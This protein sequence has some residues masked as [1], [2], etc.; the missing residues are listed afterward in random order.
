MSILNRTA[1]VAMIVFFVS[2][3]AFAGQDVKSG[4][5]TAVSKSDEKK[6][7]EEEMI[8]RLSNPVEGESEMD[9]RVRERA[10]KILL[11][12]REKD[13]QKKR[14]KSLS[15]VERQAA[16]QVKGEIKREAK[17]DKKASQRRILLGLSCGKDEDAET[18]P[19]DSVWVS[20]DAVQDYHRDVHSRMVVAN[21]TPF[22][23]DEI[24]LVAGRG[25][26]VQV[27]NFCVGGVINLVQWIGWNMYT[28]VQYVATVRD[29]S[30]KVSLSYSPLIVMQA[31]QS[32][33]CQREFSGV[34]EIQ[35][36]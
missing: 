13:A 4:D 31:C 15:L 9:A 29:E 20:N 6:E 2:G 30:G 33:T 26:P 19:T 14:E 27:K 8:I 11:E 12:K 7:T 16:A 5:K 24:R 17:E 28:Q 32:A 21:R 34:W 3:F 22:V 1:I 36:R 25:E 18:D 23:I 35:A 10:L